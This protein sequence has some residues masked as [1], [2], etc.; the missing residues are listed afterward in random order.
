MG[1]SSKS[2]S[3]HDR[4]NRLLNCGVPFRITASLRTRPGATLP[5]PIPYHAFPSSQISQGIEGSDT[6]GQ[7]E[8]SGKKHW[9]QWRW[10]FETSRKYNYCGSRSWS[11]KRK[12]YIGGWQKW[13]VAWRISWAGTF[14]CQLSRYFLMPFLLCLH[15]GGVNRFGRQSILKSY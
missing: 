10:K 12:V 2:S 9:V 13:W 1:S 5:S 4:T 14:C 15:W 8:E 7:E 11:D 6:M 3:K